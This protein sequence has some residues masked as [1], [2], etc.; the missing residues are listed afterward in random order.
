MN[1][2]KACSDGALKG[3]ETVLSPVFTEVS[4]FLPKF[5]WPCQRPQLSWIPWGWP[6]RCMCF[7]MVM[8]IRGEG[9][10]VPLCC[11]SSCVPSSSSVILPFL[12][13]PSPFPSI[14][15]SASSYQLCPPP[16]SP[17]LLPHPLHPCPVLLVSG[18]CFLLF[19]F[20]LICPLLLLPPPL[21]SFSLPH[22]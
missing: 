13:L 22:S 1:A 11:F 16:P 8:R 10:G 21:L 12:P 7:L 9:E 20:S 2:G 3:H 17:P 19:F 6:G 18:W 15:S 14:P 4:P 5:L